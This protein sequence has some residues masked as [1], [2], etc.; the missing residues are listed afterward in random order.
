MPAYLPNSEAIRGDLLEYSLEIEWFDTRLCNMIAYLKE[1]GEYD[2]TIIIVTFDNGMP[3]PR[4]KP[5]VT[6]MVFMYR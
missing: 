3:F 6:R 2:N 4:Q 1:I 5:I